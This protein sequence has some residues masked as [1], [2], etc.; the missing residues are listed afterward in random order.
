MYTINYLYMQYIYIYIM[1]NFADATN[2]NKTE[3]SIKWSYIPDYPYRILI[4]R[5]S[6][7]RKANSMLNLIN[8][9]SDPYEAK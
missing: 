3:H 4:I 8:H 2:E 7:S 5:G 6:G 9:Q 1:I